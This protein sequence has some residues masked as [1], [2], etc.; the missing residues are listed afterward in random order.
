MTPPNKKGNRSR[1]KPA[2][3][4]TPI[5][6]GKGAIKKATPRATEPNSQTRYNLRDRRNA[7][8]SPLL[9]QVTR[10]GTQHFFQGLFPD[11]ANH[12]GI[13]S[14]IFGNLDDRDYSAL[15]GTNRAI[16]GILDIPMY[17]RRDPANT[18]DPR[19]A[20]LRLLETLLPTC[21]EVNVNTH[22]GNRPMY[23]GACP[24]NRNAAWTYIEACEGIPDPDYQ[25]GILVP[26][27]P[28]HPP[29]IRHDVCHHCR[30]AYNSVPYVE[31][32]Q[33]YQ[34]R[35]PALPAGRPLTNHYRLVDL[36][37]YQQVHVCDRCD[38]EQRRL[39]PMHGRNGC[40]CISK[41]YESH[42]R[43][44]RC[45]YIPEHYFPYSKF[46]FIRPFLL[47]KG[48][49]FLT[50]ARR[51]RKHPDQVMLTPTFLQVRGK[52]SPSPLKKLISG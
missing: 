47:Q 36:V 35:R 33:F 41:I 42:H 16:R 22:L 31:N 12:G 23:A 13:L 24:H 49:M 43:C 2:A 19:G 38:L 44:W 15:R 34:T 4:A 14:R 1:K 51:C 50:R 8:R 18:R 46:V 26:Q 10:N 21:D 52:P 39:A 9:N 7:R 28:L 3:H 29:G 37:R 20:P 11:L 27:A 25:D 6:K 32:L 30:H 45:E 40:T 5:K 17:N 48:N